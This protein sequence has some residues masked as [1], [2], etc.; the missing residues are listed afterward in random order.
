MSNP[1]FARISP[2]S[3]YCFKCLLAVIAEILVIPLPLFCRQNFTIL[4]CVNCSHEVF[5]LCHYQSISLASALSDQG[6]SHEFFTLSRQALFFFTGP[7]SGPLHLSNSYINCLD[8]VITEISVMPFPLF[9]RQNFTLLNWVNYS[10]EVL[11]LCQDQSISAAMH[12]LSDQGN[13]KN[14]SHAF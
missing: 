4:S 6:N 13:C 3:G 1:G 14:L 9:C 5:R 11:T 8:E 12:P 2:Y 10:N 7:M